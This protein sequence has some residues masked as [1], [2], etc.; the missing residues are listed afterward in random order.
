MLNQEL[1]NVKQVGNELRSNCGCFKNKRWK[2]DLTDGQS[3]NS[4]VHMD[5]HKLPD[6]KM[7]QSF[8]TAGRSRVAGLMYIQKSE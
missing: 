1:D 4:T 3:S 5:I 2:Q 8:G 6:R 7:F